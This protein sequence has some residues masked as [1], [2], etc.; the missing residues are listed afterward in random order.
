MKY[1]TSIIVG[2]V[3]A[4]LVSACDRETT[5][6]DA[7]AVSTDV[8]DDVV[9]EQKDNNSGVDTKGADDVEEGMSMDVYKN[10]NVEK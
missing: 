6:T 5:D 2:L 4:V 9:E 7:E 10:M 8:Y 1:L 3:M